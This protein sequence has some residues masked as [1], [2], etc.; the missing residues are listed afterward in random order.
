VKPSPWTRIVYWAIVPAVIL[1][2]INVIYVEM[3]RPRGPFGQGERRMVLLNN[4]INYLFAEV[5]QVVLALFLIAI[6]GILWKASRHPRGTATERALA[7]TLGG[8]YVLSAICAALLTPQMPDFS[9][10]FGL[11]LVLVVLTWVALVLAI[12]LLLRVRAAADAPDRARN[13]D[14]GD[15]LKRRKIGGASMPNR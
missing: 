2:A 7:I 3:T 8:V 1:L 15:Q 6:G 12:Q 11:G 10:L 5:F 14:N 4:A 9:A 13:D